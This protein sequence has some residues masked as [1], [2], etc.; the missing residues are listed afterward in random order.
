MS[1]PDI[2]AGA[3]NL[4]VANPVTFLALALP[5]AICSAG[6]TVLS[7]AFADAAGLIPAANKSSTTVSA[8]AFPAIGA[9]FLLTVLAWCISDAFTVPA[10]IEAALGRKPRIM[11]SLA[12][13]RLI[14][15]TVILG[16]IILGVVLGV[17]F[18]TVL[19]APVGVYLM[20]RWVFLV[21]A[22]CVERAG[23]RRA[24][25]RSYAVVR[26]CW[27]RTF[28]VVVA[29]S[30]LAG[31]PLLLLQPIDSAVHS[32]PFAVATLFIAVW[33]AAPFASIART[34]LFADIRLRKG[35]AG[36]RAT[37]SDG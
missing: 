18:A 21:Q 30:L 4:Y 16:G 34:L 17:L 5:G 9:I 19:L 29:I 24:L 27:W 36:L 31:L 7:N 20:F 28:G 15:F 13:S 37:T 26:G 35:E 33:I 1:L 8:S 23:A 3:F 12:V 6:I 32:A 14:L 11:A 22:A 2:V 25:T 10:A